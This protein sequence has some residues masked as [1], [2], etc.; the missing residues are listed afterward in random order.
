[1]FDSGIRLQIDDVLG[2][3]VSNLL[4]QSKIDNEII[5]FR[6]QNTQ[7]QEGHFCGYFALAFATAICFG[8]SPESIIYDQNQMIDHFLSCLETRTPTMFPHRLKRPARQ[9][10]LILPYKMKTLD[11]RNSNLQKIVYSKEGKKN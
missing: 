10:R 7:K 9:E 8:V 1:M 5:Y 6:I 4:D 11:L 3:Q 2:D